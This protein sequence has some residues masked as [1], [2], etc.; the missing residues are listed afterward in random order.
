MCPIPTRERKA[1]KRRGV[2]FHLTSDCHINCVKESIA[3]KKPQSQKKS[4]REQRSQIALA[5]EPVG[6]PKINKRTNNNNQSNRKTK[7]QTSKTPKKDVKKGTSKLV[8]ENDEN[9][10]CALCRGIYGDKNDKHA[11]DD[12]MPC[13][14]C[15][16]KYHETCGEQVGL[17]DDD[18]IFT[19][20]D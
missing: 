4:R 17:I 14:E 7:T 13:V 5:I 20:K 11:A 6:D 19:C 1:R 9:W 2:N 3:K 12:W 15:K 8:N 10:I 16:K 18:D